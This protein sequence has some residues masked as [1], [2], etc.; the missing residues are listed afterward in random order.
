MPAGRRKESLRTTA[1]EIF[2][3]F[4]DHV[5]PF[6]STAATQFAVIVDIRDRLGRPIDSFDAQIA[7]ICRSGKAA[8]ATRNVKNFEHTGIEL[9]DPWET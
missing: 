2:T 4:D 6:D 9:I 8:L 5:L 1:T 7:S 3:A